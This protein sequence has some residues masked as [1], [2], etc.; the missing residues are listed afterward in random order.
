MNDCGSCVQA[1]RKNRDSDFSEAFGRAELISTDVFDTLLLRTCRSER[2]RILRGERLFSGMLADRG[3]RIDPDILVDARLSSQQ[4]AFRELA[5]RGCAGEVRLTEIISRQLKMFALPNSLVDERLAIEIQVE[6]SSLFANRAL[7]DILRQR[8][9]FGTRLVAIS[10]TTLPADAVTELIEH[11]HGAGLVDRVYSSAD[12]D[13]TKRDGDLFMAVARAENVAAE[14][15][16]HV[17]DDLIADLRCPSALGISAHY[18]A[19]PNYRRRIRATNG[20]SIE[21]G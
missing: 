15:I 16:A 12:Q 7:A 20:A 9:R 5:A 14:R 4:L 1:M 6:K 21:A 18:A 10:D 8:K 17:G 13:L 11:F 2:S 3:W 19:R